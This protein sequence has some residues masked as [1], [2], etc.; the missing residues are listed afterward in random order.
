M[1]SNQICENPPSMYAYP[2]L[3]IRNFNLQHVIILRRYC[4]LKVVE[5]LDVCDGG[6]LQIQH[7]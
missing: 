1:V 6:F 3:T 7:G 5:I 4:K 2:F